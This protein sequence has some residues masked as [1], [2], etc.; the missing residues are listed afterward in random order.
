L[1]PKKEVLYTR[2]LQ[3]RLLKRITKTNNSETSNSNYGYSASGDSPDFI[4]TMVN[5]TDTITEKYLALA[6]G[7]ILTIR[8][9]PNAGTDP[10]AIASINTYSLPNIHGDIFATIDSSGVLKNKTIT[11]SFG[12]KLNLPSS[13]ELTTA[14]ATTGTLANRLSVVYNGA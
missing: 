11:G 10:V 9:N 8:P 1:K 12:E 2:D 6:G 13:T 7:V 3:N 4:S 14:I 5:G